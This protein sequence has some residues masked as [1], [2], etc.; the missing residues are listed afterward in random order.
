ME[1]IF[2]KD[3]G[4]IKLLSD[5]SPEKNIRDSCNNSLIELSRFAIE[6]KMRKDLFDV[7]LKFHSNGVDKLD[8]ESKR[9]VERSI[10]EG[11]QDGKNLKIILLNKCLTTIWPDF[12]RLWFS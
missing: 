6:M 4:L 7:L 10:I 8:D 1:R 12:R 11:K 5:T 2:E 3:V 9:Y